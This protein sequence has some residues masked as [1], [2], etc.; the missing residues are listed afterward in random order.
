MQWTSWCD[1]GGATV[2]VRVCNFARQDVRVSQ[3]G[4]CPQRCRYPE[5][6]ER[7]ERELEKIGRIAGRRT[8]DVAASASDQIGDAISTILSKMVDRVRKGGRVAGDQAG[9]LG[10]QALVP[11]DALQRVA[12]EAEQR[13]LFTIGVALGIGILIGAAVFGSA[14]IGNA[15]SQRR[16]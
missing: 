8:S 14:S 1:G 12:N 16:R 11:G 6:S 4:F 7:R 13:A 3:I 15:G 5:A 2:P 9:R 10:N